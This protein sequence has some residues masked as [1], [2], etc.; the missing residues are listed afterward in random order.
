MLGRTLTPLDGNGN[1][2]P[3]VPAHVVDDNNVSLSFLAQT[4]GP[5]R[6]KHSLR[7]FVI[8]LLFPAFLLAQ[9]PPPQASGYQLE[10]ADSFDG[11]SFS[12]D[13][14]GDYSWYPGVPWHT[15]LPLPSLMTDANSILQLT[16]ARNGGLHDTTITTAAHDLSHYHVYRYGYFEA[17]MA[18]DATTGSWPAFWMVPMQA[19]QGSSASGEIDIFEGQGAAPHTFYGS[20]HAWKN[21]R[22]SQTFDKGCA[23]NLPDDN[24]FS[25]WHTYGLLWTPG[26][27]T[28]Y[29]DNQPLRSISVPSIFDRENFFLILGSQEGVNWTNGNLRG[30][31]VDEINLKIDWVH[32]FQFQSPVTELKR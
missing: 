20:V 27:M 7:R 21:N 4:L 24:D 32:V 31:R 29:Y 12:P 8:T 3:A 9:A 15:G 13:G 25:A 22:T 30:V 18:W 28:W 2:I 11:L 5:L 17:R 10:F 1:K 16:W 6:S 23:C 26:K 14:Y 19:L